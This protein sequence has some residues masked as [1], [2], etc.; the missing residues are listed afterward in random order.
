MPVNTS[1]NLLAEQFY[2]TYCEA[3]VTELTGCVL[4]SLGPLSVASV[5]FQVEFVRTGPSRSLLNWP[6]L[7]SSARGGK[8]SER[9]VH[10]CVRPM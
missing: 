2:V 1:L 3:C 5:A 4:D 8:E 10:V 9:S 6:H 7:A